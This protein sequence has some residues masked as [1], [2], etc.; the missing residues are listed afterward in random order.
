[1]S[2][3]EPAPGTA[4]AAT[5]SA[6]RQAEALLLVALFL[7]ALSLRP[8]LVGIGPL[9]PRIQADLSTTFAWSGL[10][11]TIPILCMGVF[12]PLAPALT[13]RVGP[14]RGLTVALLGLAAF[15]LWRAVVMS[16]TT[17]LVTTTLVGVAMAVGGTVLPMVVKARFSARPAAAT[18][19]YA[20]GIQLGAAGSAMTA[21]P[22]ADALGGWRATLAVFSALALLTGVA[23]PWIRRHDRRPAKVVAP[24]IRWRA[25]AA[26][27]TWVLAAAFALQSIAFFGLVAWM[28][29]Y[30]VE[31]GWTETRAGLL[32][33]TLNVSGL[34]TSLTVPRLADR[35]GSRRLYLL[36]GCAGSAAAIGGMLAAPGAGWLWSVL[37]GVSLSILFTITLTL[38]LD[39]AMTPQAAGV[40]SAFVLGIGF[41]G[42]AAAP[43]AMG[44][45]RDVT[46]T[47]STALLALVPV[48]AV[49]AVASA[50][51]SPARLREPVDLDV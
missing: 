38:P 31:A 17:L 28:P 20:A 48:L 3:D 19:I 4:A 23:W 43:S 33:G 18:G 21:V 8:Q 1:M 22:L 2:G 47:F 12:A 6:D 10:L 50:W 24:P 44:A 27:R 7:A 9:L 5:E 15:G 16:P 37:A 34:A 35:V 40:V 42:A 29:A 49:L 11:A 39:V 32:L 30:F 14:D 45:I 36:V 41:A 13:R 25:L 51:L 26:G 46:A